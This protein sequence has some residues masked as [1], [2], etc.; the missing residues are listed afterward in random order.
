[1]T[2]VIINSAIVLSIVSMLA[3]VVSGVI[4]GIKGRKNAIKATRLLILFIW[5]YVA[6]LTVLYST[7][8]LTGGYTSEEAIV[9]STL[10]PLSVVSFWVLSARLH[11]RRP[12]GPC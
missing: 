12:S 6:S 4:I 7:R 5:I 3:M 1:M 11:V 8:M 10:F 2:T 9:Y